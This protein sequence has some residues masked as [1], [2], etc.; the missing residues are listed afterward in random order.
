MF[1]NSLNNISKNNPCNLVPNNLLFAFWVGLMDG[2]GSIQVNHWRKRC[3]QYRI[4]IKLRDH[5][6]NR[7]MLYKI[8]SLLGGSLAIQKE[9]VIWAENKRKRFFEIL[10]MFEKIPPLTTRLRMQVEFAWQ[11]KEKND[12]H[13]YLRNRNDKYK[14]RAKHT[15]ILK[16]IAQRQLLKAQQD[17]D[18]LEGVAWFSGFLEAEGWFHVTKKYSSDKDTLYLTGRLTLVQKYDSYLLETILVLLGS[19][20]T[21]QQK[22]DDFYLIEVYSQ[23]V[24]THLEKYFKTVPLWGYKR[25]QYEKFLGTIAKN[26]E[27][28]PFSN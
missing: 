22:K 4:V 28:Y 23:E 19:N 3:L 5:P 6:E 18:S 7:E 9:F 10:E 26:A 21:I 13:W 14:E 16:P 2:D 8:K 24:F 11:C 15:E 20:R 1:P 27:R 25:S 17:S 12:V